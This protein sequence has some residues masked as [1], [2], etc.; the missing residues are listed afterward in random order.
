MLPNQLDIYK[1]SAGSGKTY[2]LT[3]QYLKLLFNAPNNFRHILAVTFTNKA[4]A[5]MKER[6]L[7]VLRDIAEGKKDSS[8]VVLLMDY[9]Q[10]E[11]FERLQEKARAIYKSILHDY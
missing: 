2:L 1:A 9:L 11:N 4:T 7:S 10:E 8:Y 5:E 6:I 3:S